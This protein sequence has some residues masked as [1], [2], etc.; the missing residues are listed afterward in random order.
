MIDI[1]LST[2]NGE[3]YLHQQLESLIN[4][5]YT[6]WRLLIRDDGSTDLTLDTLKYYISIYSDKIFL[7][8]DNKGNIG[9]TRSFSTLLEYSD[10]EY[11]MFCDQD[12]IWLP[13]KIELTYAECHKMAENNTNKPVMVFTDLVL[14]GNESQSV[15]GTSF[16]RYQNMDPLVVNNPWQC[17]AMSVAA[18]CTMMINKLAKAFILPMPSELVHDHWIVCNIAFYGKCKYIDSPTIY[19]RIH[20]NNSIGINKV[21]KTY[22]LSKL[23][24]FFK[25]V[26]YYKAM[27]NTLSF[28]VNK[29]HVLFYKIKFNIYRFLGIRLYK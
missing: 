20:N 3:K 11:I 29:L 19:Y 5:T 15:I 12:D 6:D 1:L 4:Q 7:I 18:G 8:N 10:S 26:Y 28:K 9:S 22:L 14:Y 24:S 23:L 17:I 16:I 13:N 25:Q 27:F 21:T 2:Y